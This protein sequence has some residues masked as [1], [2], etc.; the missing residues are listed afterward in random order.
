MT[1]TRLAGLRDGRPVRSVWTRLGW[2]GLALL[3][4]AGFVGLG[5]WQLY[6]RA[7]KL[8]LIAAVQARADAAPVPAPGP[9]RWDQ[10]SA[11]RDRYRHVRVSGHYLHGG[12]TLVHGTS[13]LGY[14]YWVMTPLRTDR[15]FIVLVDRGHIPESLPGTPK[16]RSMLR[17][18]GQVTVT[19]LLRLSKVGGGVLRSNAPDEGIWYSRDV[20]AIA[21]AAGLPVDWVAPYFIDADAR[22][23]R[24]GWPAGG[25]TVIRFPN[26]HL[27]YAITWYAMALSVPISAFLVFRRGRAGA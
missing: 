8:D 25:L 19:G 10:A 6:R 13:K 12:E 27:I 5:T 9:G 3:L 21:A 11:A 23:G 16:F 26:H 14:G 2:A 24:D 4:F 17:P 1:R 22:P 7:W 18:R 15:G 20:D